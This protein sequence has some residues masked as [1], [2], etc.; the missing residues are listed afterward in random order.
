[1]IV[2]VIHNNDDVN[3]EMDD[4][5]ISELMRIFKLM[6]MDSV[7][8]LLFTG[9][10]SIREL[11]KGKALGSAKE[12]RSRFVTAVHFVNSKDAIKLGFGFDLCLY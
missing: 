1:M 12:G 10:S 8:D 11:V 3:V 6:G 2:N 5:S 7:I 4:N 9:F